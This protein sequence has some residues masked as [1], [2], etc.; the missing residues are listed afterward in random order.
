MVQV[1][2][3]DGSTLTATETGAAQVNRFSSLFPLVFAALY[4]KGLTRAGA[5]AAV[6]AAFGSWCVLFYQSDFAKISDYVVTI[7]G[8]DYETMP[9]ATMFL[10]ST[11]AMIVVSMVTKKPDDQHLQ[12][13][14]KAS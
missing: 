1:E 8:T 13:F 14:F 10:C 2:S 5:Y 11:V 12:R 9:V 7:P 4:W 3:M 6:I